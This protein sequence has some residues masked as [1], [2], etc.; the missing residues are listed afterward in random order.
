MKLYA[1]RAVYN[2][3]IQDNRRDLPFMLFLHGFMGSSDVFNP[4]VNRLLD[5]CNPVT[6]DLLGHGETVI[7]GDVNFDRFSAEN[8]VRDLKSIM[9]RLKLP[10]FFLYGYSM[11]GRLVQQLIADDA[12]SFHGV[13]L[14]ST[15]CGISDSTACAERRKTDEE[16]AIQIEE[17]FEK[18]VDNWIQLPLFESNQQHMEINYEEILR[19]QNPEWVAAS[20]R[21][22]GAGTMPSVC[23]AVERLELPIQLIAG[24]NDQKYVD[25]MGE[26]AQLCSDATVEIVENAGHRVHAER[27]DQIAEIITQFLNS[28]G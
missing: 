18:F 12:S 6:I 8:Q 5:V 27:P 3:T 4:V 24:K 13:I 22:F 9:G 28:H 26:M 25:K 14:E 10:R 23:D 16:L 20:L 21:G 11:G 15:H 2:V 19:R 7:S 17:N 1:K